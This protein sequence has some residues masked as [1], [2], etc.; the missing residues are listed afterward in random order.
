MATADTLI[1][2]LEDALARGSINRQ[3]TTLQRITDLFVFGA[4]HF[5]D[6]HIVLFDGIFERLIVDIE[7]SA[8]V[9]L[10][11]Q[12][13]TLQKAPPNVVRRLAFDDAID[14]AGPILRYSEAIDNASLVENANTKSQQHLLAISQ[15]KSLPE[16]VT[17]VLVERGNREVALSTARNKGARFSEA[18]YVRLVKRA[19]GDDEMAETV[20][21]R[22]EIPRH[23]FLKLLTKASDSV[24][25]KLEAANPQYKNEIQ[26][27][28]A[29]IAASVQSRAAASSRNYAT[30]CETVQTLY[31]SGR[32]KDSNIEYFAREGMFEETAVALAV[33]CDLPISTVERALVQADAG[34]TLIVAKASGLSW[35]TT[36]AILLLRAGERGLSPQ[37]LEQLS[38]SYGRLKEATARQVIDFQRQRD[39]AEIFSKQEKSS[40][41]V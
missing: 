19:E 5:G 4:N 26:K 30:A 41:R 27:V 10:A 17:D 32:L 38:V 11:K 35:P 25:R 20:G 12:L 22:E 13:A 7:T 16:T 14:V 3:A 8:R 15:R 39:R 18:G 33:R 21:S 2:E 6:D 9:A 37:A 34:A 28:V 1:R 36:K 23:H 40:G 31:N 24:R 29:E